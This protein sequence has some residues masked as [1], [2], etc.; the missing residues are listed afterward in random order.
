MNEK[1]EPNE[2]TKTST[3]NDTVFRGISQAYWGFLF[4]SCLCLILSYIDLFHRLPFLVLPTTVAS[5]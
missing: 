3:R 1:A 2:Q 4:V 5:K